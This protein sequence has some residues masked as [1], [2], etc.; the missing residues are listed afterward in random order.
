M[1]KSQ[2]AFV[3]KTLVA[4]NLSQMISS[5]KVMLKIFIF[6]CPLSSPCKIKIDSCYQIAFDWLVFMLHLA[7]YGQ[8]GFQTLQSQFY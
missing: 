1:R 2:L 3:K 6:F 4:N 7:N 5:W 8:N